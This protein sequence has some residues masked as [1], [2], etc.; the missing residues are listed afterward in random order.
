MLSPSEIRAANQAK[1]GK[2][3]A[4]DAAAPYSV[5]RLNREAKL[6]LEAGIPPLWLEAE[7]SNLARPAS[8]HLYFTLKDSKSQ[9]RCAMFRAAAA[10][11][12]VQPENGQ[13]V[14]VH[15]RLGLYEA[16]G[17]YQLVVD[18][19][20]AAGEGML[21]RAYEQLKNKLEAEGLFD[22]EHKREVP[23]FP[24]RIGVVTSSSGA[25]VRDIVSVLRRRFPAIEVII[26][27]AAVQGDEAPLQIIAALDKANERAECDVIICGRGGGS[28]EDLWAFNNE[29]LARVIFSSQIPVISAVGHE[30]D[31]C[32]ADFV[33]DLRAPTPS[34]AAELASPDQI[35]WLSHFT[36]TEKQLF[37]SI[38]AKL[39]GLSQ[40]A[41]WLE[42]RLS[43]R[44]PQQQLE[45]LGQRLSHTRYKLNAS[46]PK[47]IGE[48][49]Q[50]QQRLINRLQAAS[51]A[52]RLSRFENRLAPLLPKLHSALSHTLETKQHQLA[53]TSAKLNTVS[54]LATLGRGYGIVQNRAGKVVTDANH[55]ASGEPIEIKLS[56]GSLKAKVTSTNA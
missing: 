8:G 54:P 49:S 39:Q 26:Y 25:A 20:E 34:A 55:L 50:R 35:D 5:S 28:L 2:P 4:P 43:S 41:D 17:D 9:V 42:R 52:Q 22:P 31:Y 1:R 40:K 23:Q 38:D 11:A 21:R 46:L 7:I 29:Q 14:L 6:L 3:A 51:P 37:K 45:I 19:M 47:R 32:I 13:Q 36:N 53:V 56:E 33:A 12:G 18:K 24:R 30:V 16:R 44:S 15:G 10:R 48:A 27:P